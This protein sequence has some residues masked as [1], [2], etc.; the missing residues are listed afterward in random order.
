VLAFS[1][2]S[3][4]YILSLHRDDESR[5][6]SGVAERLAA[7][8]SSVQRRCTGRVRKLDELRKA[9]DILAYF[10]SWNLD[11]ESEI[12]L[13]YH[14]RR[15]EFLLQELDRIVAKIRG[16]LRNDPLRILDVGPGFQ[17][18]LLRKTLPE[19]IVNT[20]GFR[21]PRFEPRSQDK[22]FQF[23][24]NDAQYDENWPKIE[25]H[26]LVVMAEVLEHLYTSPVLVLNCVSTWLRNRGYLIIQTPNACALHKRIRMLTGQNP[27]DMIRETR[28]NPGHYRE[29][30]I[31]ELV[32][33]A[34]RTG[35]KAAECSTRNYFDNG[36]IK[37][38]L[39]NALARVLCSSLRQGITMTLQQTRLGERN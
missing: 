37:H 5:H 4:L 23:D 16:E 18:E 7:Q 39:Y 17:T 10:A 6:L 3:Y 2:S 22:H 36:T 13:H 34:G 24:L 27:Y 31:R 28:D 19:A 9:E 26:D 25:I 29:Y 12:F 35:F 32:S 1:S 38:K 33:I 11:Q 21:D 30:T 20:L 14:R 8:G 15:Y